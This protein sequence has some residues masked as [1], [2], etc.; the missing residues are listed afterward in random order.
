MARQICWLVLL[1]AGCSSPPDPYKKYREFQPVER[2]S[3]SE[4]EAVLGVPD[5]VEE[6]LTGESGLSEFYT[7]A[8]RKR[9][10]EARKDPLAK[11]THELV[12]KFFKLQYVVLRW[13]PY[14]IRHASGG[15]MTMYRVNLLFMNNVLIR[16][17]KTAPTDHPTR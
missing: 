7:L 11:E 4:V 14:T 3:R 1:V 8:E 2:M 15:D 6:H 9:D 13:S 17:R 16:W 5:Q 12:G 10:E